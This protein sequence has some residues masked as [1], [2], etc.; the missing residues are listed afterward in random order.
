MKSLEDQ[1]RKKS[2]DLID[3]CASHNLKIGSC[4]SLTAGLF[5]SSLASVSGA[6]QVLAGGLVTYMSFEKERLAHIDHEII[7]RFGVVSSNCAAAMAI[8][9]RKVLDCD[10][11]V[12]FTG[13]AGPKVMESKP[14]GLVYCALASH[15]D[16]EVYEFNLSLERN[17][18][19]LKLV[20]LMMDRLMNLIQKNIHQEYED[21]DRK[22]HHDSEN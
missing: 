11:C 22:D 6:S 10:Y 8:N 18:L 9:A 16:L 5:C 7:E 15:H 21:Y 3:L 17:E 12:S 14:A 4:E 1:I 20:D 2:K 13:N 19:R